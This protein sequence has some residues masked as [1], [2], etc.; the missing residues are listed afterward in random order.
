MS[1]ADFRAWQERLGLTQNEV[2]RITGWSSATIVKYRR[3]GEKIPLS[4]QLVTEAVEARL[5]KR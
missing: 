4:A 3:D 1:P 2:E 5:A